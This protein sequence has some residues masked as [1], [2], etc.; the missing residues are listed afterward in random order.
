MAARILAKIP[1]EDYFTDL[2]DMVC[3]IPPL[4]TSYS[5]Q[6]DH[7]GMD[8]LKSERLCPIPKKKD[9]AHCQSSSTPKTPPS[10]F[11]SLILSYNPRPIR[12]IKHKPPPKDLKRHAENERKKKRAVPTFIDTIVQTSLSSRSP[13]S[14]MAVELFLFSKNCGE[15]P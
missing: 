6:N 3:L 13:E 14:R 4:F 2:N 7:P 12:S 15:K 5:I 1:L 10:P 11:F 8:D 9:Y